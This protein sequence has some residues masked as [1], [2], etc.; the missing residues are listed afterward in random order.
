MVQYVTAMTWHKT[1]DSGERWP[2]VLGHHQASKM[3][4]GTSSSLKT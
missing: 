2:A 3:N 4:A 1:C